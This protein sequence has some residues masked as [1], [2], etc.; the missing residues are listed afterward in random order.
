MY[1][2]SFVV[3]PGGRTLREAMPFLYIAPQTMQ[4]IENNHYRKVDLNFVH[5]C[6]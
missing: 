4:N 1:L 3:V 6:D 2:G 5:D